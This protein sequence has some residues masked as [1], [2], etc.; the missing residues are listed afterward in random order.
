MLRLVAEQ[1]ARVLE[2]YRVDPGYIEEHANNERRI[3]QGGYGDRQIYELTQNGADE[4][5]SDE[6]RGGGIQVVL[7][8]THLYCANTGSAITP[9][10]A[11]TILRMSVSRKR[12]GQIGRFGVGVKSVLE[13]SDTP[14]FFSESGCFAFDKK[15][16]REQ[17]LRVHPR[18]GDTPVLRMARPIDRDRA[19]AEDPVLA[20]LLD[21]ATTVVRLPLKAT[22]TTRLG[23][24]LQEFPRQ[25]QLFSPHVGTVVLEDRRNPAGTFRR[26]LLV[27][28][29]GDS[30]TVQE[31]RDDQPDLIEKWRVFTRSVRP[32]HRALA[33]AGELH[34][35]PEV[36]VTWAVPV[37]S[38]ERG[39]FWA[40]FPTRYH[41]TLRGILNAPWKTSEDRQNLY[42]AND[43][44]DE[45]L[46]VAAS[47]VVDSL[48]ELATPG[49]PA[50]YLSFLP[51]RGREASQW[52]DQRLTE[53]VWDT[54]AQH[55]SLPGQDGVLRKPSELRLH[56]AGLSES[57]LRLWA[58]HEGRPVG[59]CHH[60]VEGR[61]RRPRAEM[62]FERAERTPSDV[63]EWL[64]ALVAGASPVGSVLALRILAEIVEDGSAHR[65]LALRARVLLTEEGGLVAPVS[66]KVY[67]RTSDDGLRDDLVYVHPDVSEAH[68]ADHA[69]DVLGI[70]R[71][72]A[73]GRFAGVV[74]Q[75]FRG[76]RDRDWERFWELARSVALPEAVA[77]LQSVVNLRRVVKVRTADGGYR[78]MD[79]CLFSGRVVPR[80]LSRDRQVAVHPEFHRADL[81]VLQALGMSE[82]PRTSHSPDGRPW[83]EEY[84][85]E[86][87]E[88]Y[89]ATVRRR[90]HEHTFRV[91][92]ATPAGPLQLL[93]ELSEEGRA[94]F[95]EAVPPDG[96]VTSW[97]AQAGAQGIRLQVVSPLIWMLRKHGRVRT[98]LGLRPFTDAVGAELVEHKDLLPVARLPET[99]S[100]R[101]GLPDTP[102]RVPRALWSELLDRIAV[103]ENDSFPGRAYALLLRAGEDRVDWEGAVTRCRIGAEWGTAP[104]EEITVAVGEE[105]YDALVRE[106]IPALL[107][108]SAADAERMT[109]IWGMKAFA[110]TIEKEVRRTPSSAE[111]LITDEFPHLRVVA[112]SSRGWSLLRC[113][114]LEEIVRTPKGVRT[115][116]LSF[117]VEE[118]TVLVRRPTDDLATLTS[119]DRAL[120]LGLGPTGCRNV[121]EHRERQRTDQRVS[122]ARRADTVAEKA[123]AIVG[124]ERLRELLPQ[125]LVESEEADTGRPLDD[126]SIARLAADAHGDDLWRVHSKDMAA[127][128]VEAPSR[129]DGG[130]NARRWV[131]D[132]GLPESYAGASTPRLN[133]FEVVPGPIDFPKLHDYQRDIVANL[134]A[135]L[136]SPT[137]KRG[138]LAMP[139]GS[140]KTRVAAEAVI[141]ILEG[142]HGAAPV[143]WI[144]Q[145]EELC[146]QAVQSWTFLWS[147][148]G[149]KKP[150]TISRFW[151]EHEA[152]PVTETHQLVVATDAKL[153]RTLE[154]HA[155]AWL[156]TP[157]IVLVDEA[158]TSLSPRYT[159]ILRM[160]GLTATRTERPLIGLTGTPFR[161]H[162]S[163]ETRRLALRYD[164]NR[165]DKGV[166]RNGDPYAELQEINVLA[167]VRMRELNGGEIELD[168]QE[169]STVEMGL[170]P[171]AAEQRLADDIGRTR[172]LVGEIAALPRDWPVLLFA[173]SVDHARLMAAK[174]RGR[175]ISAAAID[176]NTP[177]G[178]RRKVV[179]DFRDGR[180]R[181]LSNYGVLTQGFDA[182]ATRAVV[183]ARP[184]YSP[185][186]Y[187]QMIGRGLRGTLNGGKDECLII[188][189]RDNIVNYGKDL[190]FRAFDRLWSEE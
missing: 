170:L 38:Q 64:E 97:T 43:F 16:S 41:T 179:Q 183:V 190:A 102:D 105:E 47:L 184:T 169:I 14:Q 129:W 186:V 76:Y 9:E 151:G 71:A 127:Q 101:L 81:G 126:A 26:K 67:R 137:P 11:D 180:V 10:G 60:S 33:A 79:E 62:I 24:D 145:T 15:W 171:K 4:M 50:R 107:A 68:D 61:E 138:M 139:T 98:T 32:G 95:L 20:E 59:W 132:L 187:Q 156:R 122:R 116:P 84:R 152:T 55:P 93:T 56:P 12:G 27:R 77:A 40:F 113:S 189:V 19:V 149:P 94:A 82:G 21:W 115:E 54:A 182:P 46:R 53:L 131:V 51:G 136:N 157:E 109:G 150:L 28:V 130:T 57:W 111:T 172:M 23:R 17:I 118:H 146:E 34:E 91:E 86:R 100:R 35:R 31:Q 108:P 45:L 128:G 123:L 80:D 134:V 104:D 119:V 63:K 148:V 85:R 6:F 110:G 143:L 168:E 114:E 167:R 99:L 1:S 87:R 30:V 185:N 159:D 135:L 142:R 58:G 5:R 96:L 175:G 52:A 8:A 155:Y 153:H 22:K 121:L 174:L 48:A 162:S 29:E 144:A 178:T 140:G 70:R 125:G 39:T 42:G 112:P 83:F 72:D 164:S 25:F 13:I 65:D 158:H 78:P 117:A 160:L 120:K 75:G 141:Q 89:G 161:G 166:F 69:L 163:E 7:T 103:S 88:Q 73:A 124:A 44:N 49:D 3:T 66:G 177:G 18:A 133:P 37:S 147:R 106:G 92:G 90:P 165:L 181:V 176:A 36:D 154:Q 74:A 2:T 188:N 173:T